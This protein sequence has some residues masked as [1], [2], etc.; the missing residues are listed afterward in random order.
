[1]VLFLILLLSVDQCVNFDLVLSHDGVLVHNGNL[2][3]VTKSQT[4]IIWV[5]AC[6]I[7]T[8]FWV[9]V[10]DTCIIW[11]FSFRFKIL[12]VIINFKAWYQAH[13]FSMTS[14][15]KNITE[16]YTVQILDIFSAAKFSFLNKRSLTE[17]ILKNCEEHNEAALL[18]L[19]LVN[20]DHTENFYEFTYGV[21]FVNNS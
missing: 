4:K 18:H 15:R 16:D 10:T 19:L 7:Q 21:Y 2:L 3:E 11:S 13:L 14:A 8:S 17:Q 1:M 12:P 6:C 5:D 9:W 20:H